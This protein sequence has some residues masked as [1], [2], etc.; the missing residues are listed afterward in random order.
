M[1]PQKVSPASKTVRKR[2]RKNN[3]PDIDSHI[4]EVWNLIKDGELIYLQFTSK[5]INALTVDNCRRRSQYTGVSRNGRNWQV[6]V[7]MG[8]DKKYI[9]SYTSEK[10]AAIAYD[11]YTIWLHKMK[12]KT[13]FSYH[14]S[15]VEQM[16]ESY[17][18]NKRV[19]DPT[20]FVSAVEG[21]V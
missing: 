14:S 2:R 15:L 4:Q 1:S 6:L 13:N 20:A 9:G 17:Y 5:N 3:L 16:I 10:E 7:N 21:G 19:F 11:F 8:K 12:A 18:A